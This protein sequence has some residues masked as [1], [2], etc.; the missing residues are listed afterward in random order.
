[1]ATVSERGDI[2]S[3]VWEFGDPSRFDVFLIKRVLVSSCQKRSKGAGNHQTCWSSK[4]SS[5]MESSK[6]KS[7]TVFKKESFRMVQPILKLPYL[8]IIPQKMDVAG[9]EFFSWRPKEAIYQLPGP[10][11]TTCQDLPPDLGGAATETCVELL[12]AAKAAG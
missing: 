6:F 3:Y 7:T 5:D 12:A 1:M 4:K 9:T 11:S 8:P 10:P 2:P